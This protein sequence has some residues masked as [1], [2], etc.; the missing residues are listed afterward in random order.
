[1][2]T[3]LLISVLL[4]ALAIAACSESTVP[5]DAGVLHDR[6][7]F[8]NTAVSGQPGLTYSIGV[9]G[10]S[11]IQL[12]PSGFS[13]RCPVLS[14]DGKLIA[15]IRNEMLGVMKSD[16]SSFTATVPLSLRPPGSLFGCPSWSS[17]GT[18]LAFV[19]IV[20]A[21]KSPS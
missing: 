6:V 13:D 17:D 3:R 5:E 7:I 9:D 16:G 12:T 15:L 8:L 10:T 2:K 11:L 18:R 4:A 1:M 20:P 21:V 14:S 19:V